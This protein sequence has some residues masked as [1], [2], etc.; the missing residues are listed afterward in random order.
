MIVILRLFLNA[1]SVLTNSGAGA[2]K[3][4]RAISRSCKLELFRGK[5]SGGNRSKGHLQICAQI[6]K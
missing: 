4:G 3:L 5:G 2:L 6:G 1:R